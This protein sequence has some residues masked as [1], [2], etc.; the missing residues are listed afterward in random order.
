MG[1]YAFSQVVRQSDVDLIRKSD[2]LKKINILHG[3]ARIRLTAA[4]SDLR[5]R[6]WICQ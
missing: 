3:V 2:A 4:T 6:Y 1:G 5:E